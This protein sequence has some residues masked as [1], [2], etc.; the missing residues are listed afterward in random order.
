MRIVRLQKE[1][2]MTNGAKGIP[3][4][5]SAIIPRLVC[6]DVAGEITGR[7]ERLAME[8][9]RKSVLRLAALVGLA[10]FAAA[11]QPQT[12]S[13]AS[14]HWE[15]TVQMPNRPLSVTVDLEKNSK[16]VWIGSMSIVGS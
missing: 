10:L 13:K 16:G 7:K 9:T 2:Q 15:G 11:G 14:G 8:N 1:E 6:R 12:D 4:G 3:E 5:A